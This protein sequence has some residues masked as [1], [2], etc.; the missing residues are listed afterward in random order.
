MRW[1]TDTEIVEATE[2][3]TMSRPQPPT[4]DAIVT[5][6]SWSTA[7]VPLS[8]PVASSEANEPTTTAPRNIETNPATNVAGRDLIEA[9]AARIIAH[10]QTG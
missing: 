4:T 5:S 6:F 7:E 1:W 10:R 8:S 3:S 2:N 9:T